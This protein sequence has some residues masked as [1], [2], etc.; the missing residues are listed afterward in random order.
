MKVLLHHNMELLHTRAKQ[1]AGQVQVGQSTSPIP[2]AICWFWR[3]KNEG[4]KLFVQVLAALP[5]DTNHGA[6]N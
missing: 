6:N 3:V 5:D 2:D 4:G 1:M